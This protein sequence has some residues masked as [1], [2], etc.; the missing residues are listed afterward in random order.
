MKR[1]GEQVYLTPVLVDPED[2]PQDRSRHGIGI[3]VAEL[4]EL[5]PWVF[6]GHGSS[7]SWPNHIYIITYPIKKSKLFGLLFI[8]FLITSY[9]L[10]VTCY[11][12]FLQFSFHPFLIQFIFFQ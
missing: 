10:L 2:I 12:K 7:F 8:E 1:L 4:C 5:D 9:L 6:L 3:G 11:Q